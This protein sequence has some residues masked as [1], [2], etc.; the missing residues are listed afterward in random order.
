[1]VRMARIPV[2]LFLVAL[3]LFAQKRPETPPGLSRCCVTRAYDAK[4]QLIGEVIRWDDRF[5]T[6]PLAAIVRYPIT[7]GGDDVALVVAPE[8]ITS[9]QQP[10]GSTALFT[11]PDCSGT[12]MFAMISWPPLMKRYAMVLPVGSP[13][14]VH[15]A[16]TAAWLWVSAPLPSRTDPGATVFH[17]Q[18]NESGGC[19]PYP[20]PG[21]TVTGTPFGGFWMT[22]VE[23][24]LKKYKRP[25]YSR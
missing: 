2:V 14:T 18:W 24:L 23:D 10:G 4:D 3:P 22:R 19:T 25:F 5:P 15:F 17:S 9:L 13:G 7:P 11:T 12:T 16:P 20:A 1:M 6:V 8:T 21:F